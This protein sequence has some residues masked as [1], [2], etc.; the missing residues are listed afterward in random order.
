MAG[1]SVQ[2]QM[3]CFGKLLENIQCPQDGAVGGIVYPPVQYNKQYQLLLE[4][5]PVKPSTL[6]G[7]GA[8]R[9]LRPGGWCWLQCLLVPHNNFLFSSLNSP[10]PTFYKLSRKNNSF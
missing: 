6:P 4:P 2:E 10:S 9:S 5:E 8:F 7:P 3:Q 1:T